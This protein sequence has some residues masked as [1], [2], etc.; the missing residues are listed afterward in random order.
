MYRSKL[1][2]L[3][4]CLAASSLALGG[5]STKGDSANLD[6]DFPD[7]W[8]EDADGDGFGNNLVSQILCSAPTGYVDKGDDC[9]DTSDLFHPGARGETCTDP[10]DYN[11]DGSVA[12]VDADDDGFPACLDCNDADAAINPS[13]VETCNGIDDNCDGL[14]DDPSSADAFTWYQD[15][16]GDTYGNPAVTTVACEEP[17]AYVALPTD[18]DDTLWS[19][20]PGAAEIPGDNLDNDCNGVID[21]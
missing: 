18:C 5:C 16:D 14:E 7:T 10:N 8:Y 17:Y 2:A 4:A 20:N 12:Y 9:D 15:A 6:C 21:G 3:T 1:I 19:T 11:C 13:A